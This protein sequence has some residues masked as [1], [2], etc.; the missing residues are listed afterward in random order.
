[1]KFNSTACIIIISTTLFACTISATAQ[2]LYSARGF[3]IELNKG[4]YKVILEKK[5]KG[6][7]IS[8]DE[9][10]Y[11]ADYETYLANYYQRMSEEEKLEYVRMKDQWD[12]EVSSP[13]P[14]VLEDFNLRTRDRLINGIYGAYYGAS[15]VAIADIDEGGLVAGIPLIMAGVWQLGPVINTKKYEDISLA[16]VR[17]GN[18]GKI[19]G[20]GYGAA[21]GLAVAGDSDDSYKWILGLSS[22]GSIALGEIAFQAQKKKQL[23]LG[24]VEMM[25]L[26][27]FLGPIVTG[28]GS[29]AIDVNN[30]NLVG[31]SLV[32]GGVAGLLIGNKVANNYNYT[33]GDADVISS[34]MLISGGLGATVAV[35]TIDSETNTGLLLIPAATAVAGTIFGQRSVKGVHITKRQGSTVRLASG[36]GAL[37]GLG[38]VALTETETIGWWVGVPS[39]FAL[40]MHQAVFHS[41]KK[42]NLENSYNLG[43]DSENRIEFS[44]KVTPENYFTN[45]H[46]SEKHFANK[47]GLTYPIVSLKLVF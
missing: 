41:Y 21:L 26:Y 4:T 14:P 40:A 32:A 38:V 37:I 17:A 30:T 43:R 39:A 34:L 24:H 46:L 47:P 12:R 3:W 45:K 35:E 2:E 25:R 1:M 42:K 33:Q 9:S 36:G 29:L 31:G 23:S 10:N 15:L 6:D 13:Q 5:L 7:P 27:G 28:L 8:V 19:L 18:T 11:L 22:I 20:L 16:T 44:V